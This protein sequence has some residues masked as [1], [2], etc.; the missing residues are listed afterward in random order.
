MNQSAENSDV[1]Q[2]IQEAKFVRAK[3]GKREEMYREIC[4]FEGGITAEE[5]RK[6]TKK[7]KRGGNAKCDLFSSFAT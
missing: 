7:N 5:G 6:W 2:R 4:Q 3:G 1:I